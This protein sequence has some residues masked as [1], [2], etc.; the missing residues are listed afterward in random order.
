M[1]PVTH[2][3]IALLVLWAH[4]GE[5][6]IAVQQT[7]SKKRCSHLSE[8]GQ[9]SKPASLGDTEPCSPTLH[10]TTRKQIRT[11]WPEMSFLCGPEVKCV[12][13]VRSYAAE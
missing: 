1:P 9:N 13:L 5:N 11:L 12:V 10:V 8:V 7:S 6:H 2:H 3:G 4:Y